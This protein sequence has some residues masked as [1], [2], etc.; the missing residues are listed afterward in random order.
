MFGL[1]EI[2]KLFHYSSC[3][4]GGRL[5]HISGTQINSA[6]DEERGSAVPSVSVVHL[7]L[8]YANLILMLN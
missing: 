2:L 3:S 7:V 4:D 1:P 6:S 8:M 5:V